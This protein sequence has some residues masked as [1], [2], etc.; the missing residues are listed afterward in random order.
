MK[1]IFVYY[2]TVYLSVITLGLI[3]I[4]V[5]TH[6]RVFFLGVVYTSKIYPSPKEW[7][8]YV[9]SIVNIWFS[10]NWVLSFPHKKLV[11][12]YKSDF[13]D[14]IQKLAYYAKQHL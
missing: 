13:T 3:Q 1:N 12:V 9:T 5:L 6:V 8:S 2:L 11:M 14:D 4:K 10:K 7:L